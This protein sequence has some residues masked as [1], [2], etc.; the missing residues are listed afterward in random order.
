[1][2]ADSIS[3]SDGV[4]SHI[5]Q[6][7]TCLVKERVAVSIACGKIVSRDKF[8]S[9]GIEVSEIPEL[10]HASR[11]FSNYG[12]AVRKIYKLAR[13][14]KTGIIHSHS[15]YAANIAWV[16]SRLNGTLAVQ[17]I[18]G[19]IP[20]RGMLNH[21]KAHRYI[22]VNENGVDYLTNIKGIPADRVSFIRQGI[23]TCFVSGSNR[24]Q[25]EKIRIACI[26]RLEYEKGV[27]VFLKAAA[28]LRSSES[29]LEFLVA[30]TGS[31][32]ENLMKLNNDLRV[33]AKFPGEV[34]DVPA[35]LSNTDVLVMPGR[36]KQEGFPMII[37]EA[38]V[39]GCLI[40][41]S[42]FDSLKHSFE[43]RKDGYSFAMEDHKKLAE[44]IQKACKERTE[45]LA[46]AEHFRKKSRVQFSIERFFDEH[47]KVYNG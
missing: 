23:A 30:G 12:I 5:F 3:N 22:S 19:I 37:A 43:N 46:M 20:E 18:H 27:D 42:E 16:V 35:L 25:N 26:S 15:H 33:N 14:L 39:A 24:F 11:S 36:S 17:T 29:N 2:L 47:M 8:I 21:F 38:G 40:I 31:L 34:R 32:K 13:S 1:M 44:V 7:A 41:S 9:A 4:S 28:L 45:S 10:H 6:L